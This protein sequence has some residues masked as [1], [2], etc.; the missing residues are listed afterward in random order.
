[1]KLGTTVNSQEPICLPSEC[2]GNIIR[3]DISN[4]FQSQTCERIPRELLPECYTSVAD[5]VNN[6][7]ERISIGGTL[8]FILIILLALK[9]WLVY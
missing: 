5:Q 3:K 9:L 8:V 1:M 2:S 7:L 4:C 6:N